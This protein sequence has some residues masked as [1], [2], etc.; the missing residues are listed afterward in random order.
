VKATTI[1][2]DKITGPQSRTVQV[3]N[4]INLLLIAGCKNDLVPQ[5]AKKTSTKN[6][7]INIVE[8]MTLRTDLFPFHARLFEQ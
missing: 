6:S 5:V 8:E 1:Q 3:H 2:N 7:G 4:N